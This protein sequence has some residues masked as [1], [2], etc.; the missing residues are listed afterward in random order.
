MPGVASQIIRVDQPLTRFSIERRPIGTFIANTLFPVFPVDKQSDLYY[1]DDFRLFDYG[2]DD[3]DLRGETAPTSEMSSWSSTT[4][5][6]R[7]RTRAKMAVTP[8]Q[9]QEDLLEIYDLRKI[10]VERALTYLDLRREVRVKNLTLTPSAYGAGNKITCDGTTIP[11]MD[12]ANGNPLQILQDAKA[13][14]IASG[15]M[16]NTMIIPFPVW[17]KLIWLPKL[18]SPLYGVQLG[19]LNEEILGKFFNVKV[20]VPTTQVNYGERNRA[21][22][23]EYI[24]DTHIWVGYVN[25]TPGKRV[26]Q[27]GV[28]FSLKIDGAAGKAPRVR[29]DFDPNAGFGAWRDRCEW[30]I[31]EVRADVT[32]G[33]II[34]NALTP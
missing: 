9:A 21:A 10:E 12:A 14:C 32:C 6:Y 4:E 18:L 1:S 22:S 11:Y 5:P 7:V 25:P 23:I 3:E 34:E 24:W 26:R 31:D 19:M 30:A 2:K 8:V 27:F 20:L 17:S 33:C 16:P 28:T 29:S 15:V 13:K